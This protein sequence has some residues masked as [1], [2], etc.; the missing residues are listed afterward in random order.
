MSQQQ[1][2]IS[3]RG[4]GLKVAYFMKRYGAKLV[5]QAG[6]AQRGET[7][8]RLHLLSYFVFNPKMEFSPPL[9]RRLT[10]LKHLYLAPTSFHLPT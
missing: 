2:E 6:P 5:S 10:T 7:F 9:A 1:S 3:L 8:H 4:G